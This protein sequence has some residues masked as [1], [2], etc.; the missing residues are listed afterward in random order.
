MIALLLVLGLFRTVAWG[1]AAAEYGVAAG[2]A[3]TATSGTASVLN[4]ANRRLTDALG[5]RASTATTKPEGN[6]ARLAAV[7]NHAAGTVSNRAPGANQPTAATAG[8]ATPA[9]SVLVIQTEKGTIRLGEPKPAAKSALP[10]V[11]AKP[12][13]GARPAAQRHNQSVISS[14]AK[15]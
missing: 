2:K 1:Q 4:K 8:T 12:A 15:Q 7:S 9:N 10:A 6:A 3:A 5:Q 14:P 11:P 13:N